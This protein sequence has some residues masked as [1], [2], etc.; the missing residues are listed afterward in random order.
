MT[1]QVSRFMEL[2]GSHPDIAGERAFG[3]DRT[4]EIVE[5]M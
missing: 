5:I 4:V 1:G 2:P 3:D